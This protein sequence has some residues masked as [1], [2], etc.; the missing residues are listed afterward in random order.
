MARLTDKDMVCVALATIRAETEGFIP[1]SEFQ[2]PLNTTTNPFD[3]YDPG[4][5]IGEDLGNTQPGDGARFRGRGFV[6][7]TG[8]KNYTQTGN[9]I[10]IN[11]SA[12]PELANDPATAGKILAQFV[13]DKEEAIRVA[14]ARN[15]LAAARKAVNGRSNGLSRFEDAYQTRQ[16][17]IPA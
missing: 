7:L 8:R 9:E 2:S 3:K 1:I 16:N 13:Y 17:V 14:L 15:D 6:Q 5:T 4:T 10:H 12:S 11:P